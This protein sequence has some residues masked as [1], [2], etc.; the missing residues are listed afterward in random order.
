MTTALLIIDVQQ[1]IL[2]GLID[3]GRQVAIDREFEAVAARLGR[4]KLA[5][6]AAGVPVIIVQ[7]DGD[8]GHRLEVGSRG[9]QLREEVSAN[10]D[11]V[12]I[13][14]RSCDAFHDTDLAFRLR[15]LD[16]DRLVI[17]GCMTQFC[18]DT[19]TRRAVSEGF[20]VTLVRDGHATA[21]FGSLLAEQIVDHH[22]RL[23]SGFDAGLRKVDLL[24]ADEVR[25]EDV[26]LV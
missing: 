23:L 25:F 10:P 16:V 21:D 12:L 15:K 7:H 24:P 6:E 11:T 9:W 8:A 1:G 13:H 19:T 3:A 20:D 18:V 17:G 4:L 22:N 5:A 2:A 14:K 26:A